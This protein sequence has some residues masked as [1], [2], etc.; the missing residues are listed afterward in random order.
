MTRE[1]W[2]KHRAADWDAAVASFDQW[3]IVG[4]VPSGDPI[5]RHPVWGDGVR[6]PSGFVCSPIAFNVRLELGEEA[7][8][9]R[10]TIKG[11][12]ANG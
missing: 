11:K 7:I 4:Y 1:E 12:S 10:C 3:P 8:G 9:G 2:V 5:R 6:E